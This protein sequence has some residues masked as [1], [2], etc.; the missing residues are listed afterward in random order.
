MIILISTVSLTLT[1]LRLLALCH[2]LHKF[3]C[4]VGVLTLPHQY[5]IKVRVDTY[6]VLLWYTHATLLHIFVEIQVLTIELVLRLMYVC[7]ETSRYTYVRRPRSHLVFSFILTIY[8]YYRIVMYLIF[9]VIVKNIYDL[10]YWFLDCMTDD[11]S[12]ML[13]LLINVL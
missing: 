10:Y 5:S 8:Y 1:F 3:I 7:L 4:L 2:I 13:F 12:T 9:L 11:G 6:W